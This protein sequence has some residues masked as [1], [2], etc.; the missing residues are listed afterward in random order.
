MGRI[1]EYIE[2]YIYASLIAHLDV[3]F[4]HGGTNV[5]EVVLEQAGVQCA[6]LGIQ[7][8]RYIIR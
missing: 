8:E 6:V 1:S 2:H 4:G 3:R 5:G 7:L